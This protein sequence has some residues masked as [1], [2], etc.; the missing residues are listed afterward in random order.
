MGKRASFASPMIAKSIGY[1][2]SN[3]GVLSL[4]KIHKQ[5]SGEISQYRSIPRRHKTDRLC[6]QSDDWS[7]I[8]EA[9]KLFNSFDSPIPDCFFHC[10]GPL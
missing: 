7:S 6:T 8:A 4:D 10:R 3:F 1:S 9:V 5:S 2:C